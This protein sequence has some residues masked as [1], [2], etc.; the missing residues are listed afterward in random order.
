[1]QRKGIEHAIELVARLETKAT[2]VISHASGDEGYE[3]QQRVQQYADLLK[4][5]ARFIDR[6]IDDARGTTADGNKIYSLQDVYPF[7]DLVTYPS[8][9]EGFGNAFLEA[10]YFKKPILVNN[11]SIYSHD[12]RPKGFD[13]ILMDDFISNETVRQTKEVLSDPDRVRAM[14]ETNYALGK[15]YFSYAVLNAKLW[16]I[17]RTFWGETDAGCRD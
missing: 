15:R 2:L 17:V 13:V 6:I 10:V 11:Y 4:I 3:Y 8:I 14:G 9:F 7:A 16:H 12:I 1:V 5:D